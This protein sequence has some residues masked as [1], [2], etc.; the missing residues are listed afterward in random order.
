MDTMDTSGNALIPLV[1][2]LL[3]IAFMA[4]ITLMSPHIHRYRLNRKIKR[5]A[6]PVVQF[7]SYDAARA[8]KME[9]HNPAVDRMMT[10]REHLVTTLGMT[11]YIDR[12]FDRGAS[13]R[14]DASFAIVAE[15]VSQGYIPGNVDEQNRY[16]EWNTEDY[17][18][19]MIEMVAKV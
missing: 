1:L 3:A 17:D 19:L 14:R 18:N 4:F 7:P 9:F 2:F 8:L 16:V 11:Q 13:Y 6:A 15:L 5:E 10:V 12:G